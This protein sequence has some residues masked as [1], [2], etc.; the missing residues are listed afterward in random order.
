MTP[1]YEYV[2]DRRLQIGNLKE[3]TCVEK[4]NDQKTIKEIIESVIKV[5]FSGKVKIIQQYLEKKILPKKDL[6]IK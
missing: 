6:M 5:M 3:S 4:K 1:K 2:G